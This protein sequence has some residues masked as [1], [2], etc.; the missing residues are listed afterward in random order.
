MNKKLPWL[1]PTVGVNEKRCRLPHKTMHKR[2]CHYIPSA[3]YIKRRGSRSQ[4]TVFD[5]KEEIGV[6]ETK[7]QLW[8]WVTFLCL[9]CLSLSSSSRPSTVVVVLLLVV[10]GSEVA[11][12]TEPRAFVINQSESLLYLCMS[13]CRLFP[14]RRRCLDSTSPITFRIL[15]YTWL[16]VDSNWWILLSQLRVWPFS[17]DE[18]LMVM[19]GNGYR[20]HYVAVVVLSALNEDC[21]SCRQTRETTRRKKTRQWWFFI[22]IRVSDY[23]AKLK[24]RRQFRQSAERHP[25]NCRREIISVLP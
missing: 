14:R 5:K 1:R 19:T 20:A 24:N 12:T 7:V 17:V 8:V 11:S 13:R 23:L 21:P 9:P 18:W 16:D 15:G 10:L 3:F 6:C 4:C 2:Y 25:R 22:T